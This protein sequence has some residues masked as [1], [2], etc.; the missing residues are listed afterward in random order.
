MR[1]VSH[2]YCHPAPTVSNNQQVPIVFSHPFFPCFLDSIFQSLF[3]HHTKDSQ[4]AIRTSVEMRYSISTAVATILFASTLTSAAPLDTAKDT[5]KGQNTEVSSSA[6][7]HHKGQP[8]TTHNTGPTVT[9]DAGPSSTPKSGNGDHDAVTVVF[10]GA[11]DE[12]VMIR[13]PIDGERVS[14]VKAAANPQAKLRHV[15]FKGHRTVE[16]KALNAEGDTLAVIK[17]GKTAHLPGAL[18]QNTHDMLAKVSCKWVAV[19]DTPNGPPE[20]GPSTTSKKTGASTTKKNAEPTH[21]HPGSSPPIIDPL[22]VFIKLFGEGKNEGAKHQIAADGKKHDI[23]HPAARNIT[24]AQLL[25]ESGDPKQLGQPGRPDISCKAFDNDG[26]L[27]E[28]KSGGK[29]GS[30]AFTVSKT[31][32]YEKE[33]V[34]DSASTIH[35]VM[36][37]QVACKLAGAGSGSSTTKPTAT[38]PNNSKSSKHPETTPTPYSMPGYETTPSGFDTITLAPG[39]EATNG[40]GG[41]GNKGHKGKK[42]SS[43]DTMTGP[44]SFEPASKAGG[45]GR[46]TESPAAEQTQV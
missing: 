14:A 18:D 16:C 20:K 42:S 33:D 1:L 36:I 43:I 13:V 19:D 25:P 29:H 21:T 5:P 4:K 28:F 11:S 22:E 37:K 7:R 27:I 26:K 31:F 38:H 24:A 32:S 12:P 30:N 46:K 40:F 41:K 34:S 3:N 15:P 8:F 23:T 2:C 45:R 35:G 17:A 6:S 44:V 9:T 39:P 10:S